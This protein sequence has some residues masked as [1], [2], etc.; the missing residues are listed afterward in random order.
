MDR[1][2]RQLLR[3]A[4]AAPPGAWLARYQ[5]LAAPA[6]KLVKITAIKALQLD[7]AG[8]GC[9]IRIDTGSGLTGLCKAIEAV[10]P[11]WIED[12]LNFTYS[13]GWRA[14]KRSTRV[15]V[16][17]DEKVEMVTGLRPY[18]DNSVVDI[19]HP[20][21]AYAGASPA[22]ARSPATPRSRGSRWRCISDRPRWCGSTPPRTSEGLPEGPGLRLV[23][24]EDWVKRHLPKGEPF[25]S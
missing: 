6:R 23:L 12:P 22:A 14:L 16:L 25:C 4:L 2:R 11:R 1:T 5:A 24:D 20:D 17:T 13:E 15:P 9:L 7:N 19:L 21:S 18:L 3:A 10:D 8:D